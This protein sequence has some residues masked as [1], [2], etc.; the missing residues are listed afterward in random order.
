MSSHCLS[1]RELANTVRSHI[2]EDRIEDRRQKIIQKKKHQE[3]KRILESGGKDLS[4]TSI[5]YLPSLYNMY[6]RGGR[7]SQSKIGFSPSL[8][9]FSR[10]GDTT[11][12]FPFI[13][14]TSERDLSRVRSTEDVY[15]FTFRSISR[16]RSPSAVGFHRP[17]KSYLPQSQSVM[18][19]ANSQPELTNASSS[20]R[21]IVRPTV[22]SV[23]PSGIGSKS[24][25]TGTTALVSTPISNSNTTTSSS[26]ITEGQV[27]TPYVNQLR[28]QATEGLMLQR[29]L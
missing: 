4:Q 27:R 6:D 10:R 5:N 23:G 20:G 13:N 28:R 15:P 2:R 1:P 9:S 22:P 12:P 17:G 8:G 18:F 24:A 21:S 19:P 3:R 29:R 25:S 14:S 16:S 26:K 7:G 11:T